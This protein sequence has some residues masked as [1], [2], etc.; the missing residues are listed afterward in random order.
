MEK[1]KLANIIDTI[2]I[3]TSITL[4]CYCW[5]NKWLKNKIL[6]IIISG[7]ISFAI[8]KILYD[9]YKKQTNKHNLKKNEQVF[10][11]NCINY[12]SLHPANCK[13][14]FSKLLNG[15]P[16]KNFIIT[17]KELFYINY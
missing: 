9:I 17:E 3:T 15:K 8:S 11:E 7:I 14:Y 10:A 2:I 6:A 16:C 5:L 13:N 4:V 1:T 12:F